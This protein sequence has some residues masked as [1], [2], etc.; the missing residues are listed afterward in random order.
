[1]FFNK[2]K[3]SELTVSLS[4]EELI[5][6]SRILIIDDEEP[7]LRNDL[8]QAGFAVQHVHDINKSS[9]QIIERTLF[10]LVLL[11]FSGVGRE[12]G[13]DEGL[14]ILRH[15]K[16]VNP[17]V[18]VLSY[19]SKALSSE[20]ADFYRLTDGVLAKDAGISDSLEAIEIALRKAQSLDNLWRGLLQ[21]TGIRAGTKDDGEL[22]ARFVK[23]VRDPRKQAGL[24]EY[25]AGFLSSDEAQKAGLTLLGKLLELGFKAAT[26]GGG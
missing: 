22:Q 15:M 21:A 8:E 10:D 20:H 17:S 24:K 13:S 14:A 1:M 12:L 26:S 16:R 9:L 6:R 5:R 11:D 18:V 4:R 3:L 19:T 23:A 2:P 25:L 7:E